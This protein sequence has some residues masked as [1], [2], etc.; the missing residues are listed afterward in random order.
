MRFL[1]K[2][3]FFC[4]LILTGSSLF[5]QKGLTTLGI[6]FKPIFPFNFLNTGPIFND[7]ANVNFKTELTSGFNGGLIIRHSFSDLISLET[8]I[9]YVKRKYS[10]TI[11]D[12]DTAFKGESTYRIIGYEVPVSAMIFTRVGERLF[13]SGSL[14]PAVNMFASDIQTYDYYFNHVSSYRQIFQ[15]AING[16]IGFEYRTPKDGTI[17]FGVSYHRPFEYIYFDQVRYKYHGKDVAV[18]NQ[19]IGNYLTVD[20]RYYFHEEKKGK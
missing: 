1:S 14:G 3:I 20:L 5:A 16:N 9:N 10:L 12:S 15:F 17:Y 19:L 7:T 2:S 6:Q 13:A 11:T 4:F 18:G 8:G